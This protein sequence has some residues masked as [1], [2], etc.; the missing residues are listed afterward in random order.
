[1]PQPQDN[2]MHLPLSGV[3]VLDLTLA[4]AGN[5]SGVRRAAQALAELDPTLR[6]FA[7]RLCALAEAYQ[8]P[9][10]LRLV[11]QSMYGSE[12]A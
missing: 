4:R 8:S 7:R 2:E 11:E 6:P 12:A 9:A 1:M 5:M 10:V 3:V